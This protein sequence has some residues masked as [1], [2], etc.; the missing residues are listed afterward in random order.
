VAAEVLLDLAFGGAAI[1]VQVVAVIAVLQQ[2]FK[3]VSTGLAD[4]EAFL[5]HRPIA[6]HTAGA[7]SLLD[8]AL[9]TESSQ[10][11]GHALAHAEGVVVDAVVA[12]C[13]VVA[14]DA[15]GGT[16]PAPA[17]LDCAVL[18]EPPLTT[19]IDARGV[20]EDLGSVAVVAGSV[21]ETVVAPLPA[22]IACLALGVGVGEVRTVATALI[23]RVVSV[24]TLVTESAPIHL[25]G[26]AESTVFHAA[27]ALVSLGLH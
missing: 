2:T 21:V 26:G 10:I 7:D 27:E 11:A 17:A 3:A 13:L 23:V 12:G 1:A 20:V 24:V 18:D 5:P 22:G 8:I 6:E 19:E 16:S 14:R 9:Q 15:S 4:L 25:L